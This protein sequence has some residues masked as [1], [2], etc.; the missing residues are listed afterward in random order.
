[1]IR[2]RLPEPRGVDFLDE[3]TDETLHL[4]A[5]QRAIAGR[6]PLEYLGIDLLLV[7]LD[8]P[9]LLDD[10][11]VAD[12]LSL[13]DGPVALAAAAARSCLRG[14][15]LDVPEFLARCP[16]LL[17]G[18]AAERV[19]NPYYADAD[20]AR[21]A[22]GVLLPRMGIDTGET[23]PPELAARLLLFDLA[24]PEVGPDGVLRRPRKARP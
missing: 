6:S 9:A 14:G 12:A 4:T 22:V 16:A 8:C 10:E 3:E 18:L 15:R 1:M 13:I 17:H 7:A 2:A 11:R 20:L 24:H 5:S 23:V 21:V 19:A